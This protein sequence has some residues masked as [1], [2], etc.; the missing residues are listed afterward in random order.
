MDRFLNQIQLTWG[1]KVAIVATCLIELMIIGSS[2]IEKFGPILTYCYGSIPFGFIITKYWTGRDLSAEGSTNVGMANSYNVGGMVPAIITVI[3]EIS[4]ALVPLAIS[5][6]FFDFSLTISCALLVGSYLGTNFSIFLNGKGG[7]GTT[8]MLWSLFFLSP[9]SAMAL[10]I[11]MVIAMKLM[12]DS[13]HMAL[14]NYMVGPFLVAIIDQ[15]L[16]LI[17]FVTFAAFIYIIKL[18]RDMDDFGV[19]KSMMNGRSKLS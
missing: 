13:Y 2:N 17:A 14:L 7:M 16:V 18:K 9:F 5:Y 8:M 3:G 15:R 4:K 6:L 12:K 11:F 1:L 10:L 19:R